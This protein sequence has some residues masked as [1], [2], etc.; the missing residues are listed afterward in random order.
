VP[1]AVRQ[2]LFLGGWSLE[3]GRCG[4][5]GRPPPVR[6]T[7]TRA[8]TSGGF[9]IFN[10]IQPDGNAAW[11]IEAL[12]GWRSHTPRPYSFG[13]KWIGAPVDIRTTRSPLLS[14]PRTSIGKSA[15]AGN[16]RSRESQPSQLE[17]IS[18]SAHIVDLKEE[19]KRRERQAGRAKKATTTAAFC[20]GADDCRAPSWLILEIDIRH[21]KAVC[22]LHDEAGVPVDLRK[23]GTP[24]LSGI[25]FL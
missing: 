8:E 1:R 24:V 19:K 17:G 15:V 5:P 20:D 21:R 18:L 16:E 4:Y 13:R 10:S 7:A 14:L 9:C 25:Y 6:I 23:G 3:P 12:F 22:V 11:R 2:F